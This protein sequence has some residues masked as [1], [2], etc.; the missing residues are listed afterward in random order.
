VSISEG[1]VVLE[2]VK[3]SALQ[4]ALREAE[5]AVL[6]ELEV[7]RQSLGRAVAAATTG[8]AAPAEQVVAEAREL[9]RRYGEVHDR[10]MALIARQAPVAGD[11]RLVIALLHVN[12]RIERM[13]SQ[14]VNIAKLCSAMPAGEHT[15]AEQLDCLAAM[16]RLADE[17]VDEAG[18]AFAERDPEARKRLR[19]HDLEINERNRRCFALAIQDGDDPAARETAFFVAMMARALERIGDNA[20]DIGQQAAFVV[21]GRLRPTATPG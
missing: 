21:S 9:E 19:D 20:V 1:E 8:E 16:A 3:R 17:Q 7:V 5:E 10:L 4:R 13:G 6:A 11:L 18:R 2:T 15:S 14:C 12:D